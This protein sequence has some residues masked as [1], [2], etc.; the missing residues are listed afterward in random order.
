MISKKELKHFN[1]E[2][3]DDFYNYIVESEKNG[4]FTQVKE[5]IKKL[6][7]TQYN[8]FLLYLQDNNT[9]LK[10]HFLRTY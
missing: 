10:D 1:F 7:I 2:S 6:S 5:L 4:Q 8:D 3:M 9:K